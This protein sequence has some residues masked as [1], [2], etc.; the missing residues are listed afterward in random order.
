MDQRS[1]SHTASSTL[2]S[3]LDQME[4]VALIKISPLMAILQHMDHWDFDIQPMTFQQG[5]ILSFRTAHDSSFA[6]SDPLVHIMTL[7][8]HILVPA[9]HCQPGKME[10]QNLVVVLRLPPK[11]DYKQIPP[12]SQTWRSPSSSYYTALVP[13]HDQASSSLFFTERVLAAGFSIIAAIGCI[14]VVAS[15]CPIESFETDARNCLIENFAFVGFVGFVVVGYCLWQRAQKDLHSYWLSQSIQ[16]PSC[17]QKANLSR[18]S[19]HSYQDIPFFEDEA[20]FLFWTNYSFLMIRKYLI[21]AC[22][23]KSITKFCASPIRGSP[24][25]VES[26]SRTWNLAINVGIVVIRSSI[27]RQSLLLN[28][29]HR[30]NFW[31]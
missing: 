8:S 2:Q 3:Y 30:L 22:Q 4:L 24:F 21:F 13:L 1:L 7:L 18:S 25:S 28:K 16:A 11:Q 9:I 10:G 26:R 6:Y 12:L 29:V 20:S 23:D 15:S 17:R 19:H 31:T 14:V 27:F 5:A